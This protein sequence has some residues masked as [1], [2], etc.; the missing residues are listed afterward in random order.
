MR[1]IRRL[2]HRYI[3]FTKSIMKENMSYRFDFIMNNVGQLVKCFV[4]FFLW[5]AVY[6]NSSITSFHGFSVND[7]AIYIFMSTITINMIGNSVDVSIGNEVWDGS[8]SMN[9]IKPINYQ[10]KLLF[11]SFAK[12]VQGFL[13]LALPLWLGL[14]AVRFITLSEYPPNPGRICLYLISALL[15]YMVLFL[16]NFCFG[17]LSFYVTNI[18]G[19]R[20]LKYAILDFLSGVIIPIAFL[21]GWLQ[22]ILD[23]VP[24]SS[25]NYFPV[26]IYLGKISNAEVLRTLMIQIVW[27]F[28]LFL[29]SK[30]LWN[31]AIK[32]LTLLGG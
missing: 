8:I 6:L 22:H 1:K 10:V 12:F 23:F 25:I 2:F 17:I 11:E 16:I 28:V 7:I 3:P 4:L 18:W 24:F 5:Q 19:I 27:I 20:N 32:R 31:K 26:I 9:L 29:L 21:P 13:F 30:L 14:I 15:G